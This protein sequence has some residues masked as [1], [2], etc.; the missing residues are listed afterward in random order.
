MDGQRRECPI[1][2]NEVV[3]VQFG[4]EVLQYGGWVD[5]VHMFPEAR[6]SHAKYYAETGVLSF[7]FLEADILAALVERGIPLVI[8]ESIFE[9]EVE[10]HKN[11]CWDVAEALGQLP[12]QQ[13]VEQPAPLE[14]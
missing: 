14:L 1:I 10:A 3:P 8:R 11:Y 7:Q 2:P 5:S 13:V 12:C 4:D 9:R 6:L